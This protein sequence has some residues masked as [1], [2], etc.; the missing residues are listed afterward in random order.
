MNK[1]VIALAVVATFIVALFVTGPVFAQG[2][3]PS[4]PVAPGTGNGGMIGA[5]GMRGTDAPAFA[6]GDEVLHDAMIAFYAQELGM[7]V[8]ELSARMD[9]GETLAQIAAEK[10]LTFEQVR[11]LIASAQS[12][13]IDQAVKDG[14]LTQEQAEWMKQRGNRSTTITAPRGTTSTAPRGRM[15]GA[16][17]AGSPDCPYYPPTTP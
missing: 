1:M 14:T 12:Q 15:A 13:A 7:P 16:T 5:R 11:A 8:D 17:Y 10:G 9:A 6:A 3:G 4:A 2:N